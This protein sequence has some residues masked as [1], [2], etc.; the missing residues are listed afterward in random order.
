[1]L[2]TIKS[3]L[4]YGASLTGRGTNEENAFFYVAR[5]EVAELLLAGRGES[6]RREALIEQ[7]DFDG[8]DALASA[9]PGSTNKSCDENVAMLYI[10]HGADTRTVNRIGRTTLMNVA[11]AQRA[12]IVEILLKRQEHGKNN[13]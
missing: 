6:E 7:R 9:I 13:R 8:N 12:K 5:T 2:R 3:L 10:A 4:K 1:M 11:W